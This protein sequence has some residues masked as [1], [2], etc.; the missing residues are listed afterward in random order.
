VEHQREDTAAPADPGLESAGGSGAADPVLQDPLEEGEDKAMAMLALLG[1]KERW[2]GLERLEI[3]AE[4]RLPALEQPVPVRLWRDFEELRFRMEQGNEGST[5]IHILD[6]ERCFTLR[7]GQL[8]ELD[9]EQAD[10]LQRSQQRNFYNT[11]RR[12][13]LGSRLIVRSVEGDR[14]EIYDRE[15]ED[16]F[17]CWIETDSACRPLRYGFGDT[18]AVEFNQWTQTDGLVHPRT[19]TEGG[20]GVAVAILAFRAN[21]TFG[22]TLFQTPDAH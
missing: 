11:L 19:Y 6:G 20:G 12:L 14:L 9:A 16:E 10:A 13:A 3:Q 22:E 21:P 17:L 2:A 18:T 5:T 4:M 15:R 8:V 1:G 7:Q